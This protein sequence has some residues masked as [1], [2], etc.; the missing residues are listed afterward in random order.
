MS[1]DQPPVANTPSAGSSEND[2]VT[3]DPT[4]IDTDFPAS[5]A[6]VTILSEG[7]R[8]IG[9][10]LLAQGRGPHPT[11]LLLHGLPGVEQN[12]D[13]AQALRRAGWN[14]VTF[15]YRGAWGSEG[16][17]S[18]SHVLQDTAAALAH[19]R[20]LAAQPHSRIDAQRIVLVGHSVGGFAALAVAAQDLQLQAVASIAGFDLGLAGARAAVDQA[21]HDFWLRALQNAAMLRIGDA[22]A[23]LRDW[24]TSAS[25]WQLGHWT[26]SLKHKSVLLLAASHDEIAPMAMHHAPLVRALQLRDS[27]ALTEVVID[28]DHV[29]S[30]R[31]I[32]L[33]RAVLAWLKAL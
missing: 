10:V 21:T 23:F 11:V 3:C 2:P 24:V 27:V 30:D 4:V 7:A 5:Q 31:R 28:S 15:H 22:Q 8:M 18:F 25:D 16:E 1:P 20:D 9:R 32:A 12:L 26:Q 17:Y 14:V 29:F 6:S 19:V 33:A 13:L